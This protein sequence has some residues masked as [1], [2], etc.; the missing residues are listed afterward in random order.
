MMF[1]DLAVAVLIGVSAITGILLLSP[2]PGDGAALRSRERSELRDGLVSFVEARG[3]DWFLKTS[4][5]EVCSE[6]ASASNS[7]FAFSATLGS[8]SCGGPPPGST[9]VTL[10]L[11]L[12]PLQ[13]TLVSWSGGRA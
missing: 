4:P 2:A 10:T 9:Y 3:I 11:D 6:M 13:V 1:V 7:S 5:G 8:V 12:I